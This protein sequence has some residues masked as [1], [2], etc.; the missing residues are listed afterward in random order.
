[1]KKKLG[2]KSERN[3]AIITA[4]NKVCPYCDGKGKPSYAS[5]GRLFGLSRSGTSHLISYWRK[6]NFH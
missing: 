1:M 3:I 2:Y 4:Y 6:K 5:I